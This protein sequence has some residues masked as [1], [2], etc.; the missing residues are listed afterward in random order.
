[1]KILFVSGLYPQEYV[2][3][4]RELAL[5]DIQNAANVFQW[6]VVEGLYKNDCDFEVVT[7]PFLP[8]YPHN[9]KSLFTLDGDVIYE[10]NK[11]GTML[12]YCDLLAVKT[13][14]IQRNL[15]KYMHKWAGENKK[16]EQLVILTYTPYPPFIEAAI[17][18][19]KKY[20]NIILVSIVTDLVDDMMNFAANRSNVFKR[21][22]TYLELYKTKKLYSQIDK[23]VLLSDYMIEKIPEAVG[24]YTVVEGICNIKN[25]V[26]MSKTDKNKILLYAGTLD[27]FSGVRDLVNAFLRT[28]NPDFR[29]IICGQGQLSKMIT[30]AAQKDNRVIY[31]G[32]VSR[33]EV[34]GLQHNA[35]LLINPRKP[36][37]GITK[38]SFPSKTM[39]YLSSGTPML[40]YKLE[41][42]P[43][44]YYNYYYT[45]D[46]LSDE[47]LVKT[48]ENIMS[49][50]Q[51]TLDEKARLAYHFIM[52]NKTSEIQNDKENQITFITSSFALISIFV[53]NLSGFFLLN[54]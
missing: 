9:Y 53:N 20:Q 31:K 52:D 22:Q 41:G 47:T 15:E 1:M 12:R 34:L 14:S 32:L 27:E 36:N 13:F 16:E 40:G 37:G 24:R 29:L 49:L 10:G 7:L 21:L 25:L 30:E 18:V 54:P 33:D 11:V 3:K 39:E 42:I 45:V 26:T 46:D 51:E 5:N 48:I 35:T 44:E 23:Y 6:G 4:Y 38:Y 43:E 28:E 8:S 2:E 50:P 19:K 17:N